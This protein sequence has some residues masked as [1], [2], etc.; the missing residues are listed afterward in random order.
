MQIFIQISSIF[1]YALN[2]QI[3]FLSERMNDIFKKSK[4]KILKKKMF[5]S[6]IIYVGV[7]DVCRSSA[8]MAWRLQ[9]CVELWLG[10]SLTTVL[11]IFFNSRSEHKHWVLLNQWNDKL[12]QKKQEKTLTSYWKKYC[13]FFYN[14]TGKNWGLIL[15]AAIR[16]LACRPSLF[17][18]SLSWIL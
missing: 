11:I 8:T 4:I 3:K 16:T 5:N 14:G 15:S 6:K 9:W 1:N 2:L 7:E 18:Y 10:F 13:C 12:K 17:V